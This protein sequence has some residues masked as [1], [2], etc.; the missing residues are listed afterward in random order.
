MTVPRAH[1]CAR[2]AEPMSGMSS[3]PSRSGRS[4]VL[5]RRVV[6]HQR[7]G[8]AAPTVVASARDIGGRIPDIH[9]QEAGLCRR[10]LRPPGSLRDRAFHLARTAVAGSAG[11]RPAAA[12]GRDCR[13]S[14]GPRDRGIP[15]ECTGS[16]PDPAFLAK[17]L[18][19]R[20]RAVEPFLAPSP[21]EICPLATTVV[22]RL[23]K[24]AVRQQRRGESASSLCS[25]YGRGH[26]RV[27]W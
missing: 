14:R 9:A 10:Q 20:C 15:R 6:P 16:L 19:P 26:D 25:G 4:Y 5:Q 23:L 21:G 1:G 12:A 27:L 7:S 11:E 17:M 13:E 18:P 22:F 8:A 24:G 2:V 3:K